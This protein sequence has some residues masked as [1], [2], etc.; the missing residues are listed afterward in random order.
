MKTSSA[1][2]T[3]NL[4]L[5]KLRIFS[6][7]IIIVA[8]LVFLGQGCSA[9]VFRENWTHEL[10]RYDNDSGE[11][12]HST[13]YYLKGDFFSLS[14]PWRI[15]DINDHVLYEV[16]RNWLSPWYEFSLNDAEGRRLAFISQKEWTF[17]PRFLIY[18]DDKV[19]GEVVKKVHLLKEKYVLRTPGGDEYEIKSHM[20]LDRFDVTR[21]GRRAAVI[22]RFYS[23]LN[24]CVGIE[25]AAGE[26]DMMI[27]ISA[28]VCA[29]EPKPLGDN[30]SRRHHKPANILEALI[31]IE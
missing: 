15:T 27:L 12:I 1:R 17:T 10:D 26:D 22:Q 18:L 20:L 29:R 19:R 2:S 23:F 31:S 3:L 14:N 13:R 5:F 11:S 6:G 4:N 30:D 25:V 9:H 24:E 8:V 21:N 28:L 7:M 16:E